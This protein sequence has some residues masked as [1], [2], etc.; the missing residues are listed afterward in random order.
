MNPPSL[1]NGRINKSQ[2]NLRETKS[3]DLTGHLLI[4]MPSLQDDNFHQTVSLI[5]EHNDDGVMG[6][7]LNRP[8]QYLMAELFTELNLHTRDHPHTMLYEGGPLQPESGFILHRNTDGK[9]WENTVNVTD[10]IYLTTSK[11]IIESIAAN[12]GP[13]DYH[14]SLGYAG[15][16]AEQLTQEMIEN[17]WLT[18]PASADHIFNTQPEDIWLKSAQWLGI[19]M[20]QLTPNSGHA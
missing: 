10:E 8:S 4:A 1:R 19:N 15:W 6:I 7:T 18:T 13:S 5:C 14:I 17:S 11:D 16:S 12:E 9:R 2:I 3:D 20:L